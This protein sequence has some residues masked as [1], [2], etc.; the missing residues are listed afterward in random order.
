MA[1]LGF[2]LF[3]GFRAGLLLASWEDL[4]EV[5]VW[6]IA[7][8]FLVGM[9]FD[10]IPIGFALLPMALVLMIASDASLARKRLRRLLVYY[11]ATAVTF[12]VA[13]EIIGVAFFLHENARLNSMSIGYFCL[14]AAEFIWQNYPVWLMVPGT[15]VL[16][17]LVC[18]A[19][20]RVFRAPAHASG[21]PG[22]RWVRPV[23]GVVLIALCVLACNGGVKGGPVRRGSANFSHNRIVSQLAMNNFYTAYSAVRSSLTDSR[24]ELTLHPFPPADRAAR[25]AGEMLFQ[26]ADA[27]AGAAS[28]PLWRRTVTGKP[29]LDYNVV[30]IVMEGMAGEPVGALGNRPSHTPQFDALCR[31]GLYFDRMYAVGCRTSRGLIGLLC[32][33]PDRGGTS[34]MKMPWDRGSMLSLPGIFRRRGYRTLMIYGGRAKFDNMGEFLTRGGIDTVIQ[35]EDMPPSVEPDTW[36]VSDEVVFDKAHQTFE[37]MGDRRFFAVVLTVSNHEPYVVP[38]GR[39]AMLPPDEEG[40]YKR[41]NAYR[42]AD[43]AL[44]EY[45]R[46]ARES[47]YFQRT[48]FVLVADHGRTLH[49]RRE[50]DVPGYRVPCL[51][52]APGLIR[53]GRVSTVASQT[54]V[55]PTLLSLMGGEYEHCFLGRNLLAVAPGDG[56]ALM[57]EDDRLAMVV[58]DRAILQRPGSGPLLFEIGPNSMDPAGADAAGHHEV[59]TLQERMLSYYRM[60]LELHLDEAYCAPRSPSRR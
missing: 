5:S 39:T 31:E 4:Q 28:N 38:A 57:H 19:L 8:C 27:P 25:V 6:G 30:M 44:G 26:S 23:R 14:E 2:V 11:A 50:L 29:P 46:M 40:H 37:Q 54:D 53:P 43:W 22:P 16:F 59:A 49:P 58:G 34:L 12:A 35:Q 13:V 56:F 21:L 32:G 18:L 33:H 15:A 48:I 7:R 51:I 52:Y 3:A 9:K 20:K 55:P 36:G 42:Y 45:F 47:K 24:H 60:A 41:I 10:A 1:A 17:V